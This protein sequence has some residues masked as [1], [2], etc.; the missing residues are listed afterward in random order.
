M[1]RKDKIFILLCNDIK[2]TALTVC[3]QQYETLLGGQTVQR[4]SEGLLENTLKNLMKNRVII[5][6]KHVKKTTPASLFFKVKTYEE[7]SLIPSWEDSSGTQEGL[8]YKVATIQQ[9]D[10]S[11]ALKFAPHA[12]MKGTAFISRQ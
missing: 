1:R 5:K 7:S 2:N 4:D 11:E 3:L 9:I 6:R 12:Q 8:V 10:N